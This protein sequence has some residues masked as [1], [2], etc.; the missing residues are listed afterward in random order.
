MNDSAGKAA[1]PLERRTVSR[2]TAGDGKLEITEAAA[3]R[4]APLG[5]QFTASLAGETAPATVGAMP[6]TCRGDD[7]PHVHHFIQSEL[8]RA[9]GAGSTVDLSVDFA[10]GTILVAEAAP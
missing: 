4:L 9:L 10:R 5:T 7:T 8:F 2:K 6:C 3:S 1:V